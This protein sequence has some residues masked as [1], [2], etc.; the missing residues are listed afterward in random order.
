MKE[1]KGG[2][3]LYTQSRNKTGACLRR[4]ENTSIKLIHQQNFYEKRALT[5]QFNIG[6]RL[7]F[8]H[9]NNPHKL[10]SFIRDKAHQDGILQ[11]PLLPFWRVL[12]LISY[13]KL[14][15]LWLLFSAQFSWSRMLISRSCSLHSPE[16]ICLVRKG[17]LL[18]LRSLCSHRQKLISST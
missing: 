11:I 16:V 17:P 18:F 3:W 6:N 15:S 4:K 8:T 12:P 1:K 14:A 10:A 2:N 9:C 13:N 7:Q 5:Y